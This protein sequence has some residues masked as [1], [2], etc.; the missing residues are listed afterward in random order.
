[1]TIEELVD[2]PLNKL[3][4]A[5][6]RYPAGLKALDFVGVLKASHFLFEL[7]NKLGLFEVLLVSKESGELF[8]LPDPLLFVL[9]SVFHF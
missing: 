2:T 8:Y 5:L 6:F 4:I 9:I 7:R 3:C 1:M